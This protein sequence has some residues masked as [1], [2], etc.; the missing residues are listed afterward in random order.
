MSI[1]FE[2]LSDPGGAAG[3]YVYS[4]VAGPAV[5]GGT[6]DASTLYAAL[7]GLALEGYA[8][9]GLE[10]GGSSF[11][12]GFAI[13]ETEYEATGRQGIAIQVPGIAAAS[14]VYESEALTGGYYRV[15][16]GQDSPDVGYSYE[17]E[18]WSFSAGGIARAATLSVVLTPRP[19]RLPDSAFFSINMLAYGVGGISKE[20]L[21]DRMVASA[22]IAALY[23]VVL[24]ERF[25]LSAPA[26]TA[27]E[28][29]R[30]IVE[31]VR[32]GERLGAVLLVLIAEG[33][34]I[35]DDPVATY[36]AIA[37][38]REAMLVAGVVDTMAEAESIIASAIVLGA[39]T[40]AVF[41]ETIAELVGVGDDLGAQ[42]R[43][44]QSLI[45]GL[46]LTASAAN[47]AVGVVAVRDG[48]AITE[49]AT[50][51]AEAVNVIAE[52]LRVG[53]RIT[54][55]TGEYVAWTINTES[56]A[57]ARYENFPF[58]SF[59]IHG[60]RVLGATPAGIFAL[61]G[62]D[63]DGEDIAA[64]VRFA[65]TQMGSG[66]LKRMEAAYLGYTATGGLILKLVTTTDKRAREARL[67]RLTPRQA[68][69]DH[70][71]RVKFG[72]GTKS[73]YYG[74]EIENIDGADFGLDV[75]KVL[76]LILE[77]RITGSGRGR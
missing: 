52:A 37:T 68:G 76:P 31:D 2:S 22:D 1:V 40:D 36:T 4:A 45:D 38:V 17:A 59:A 3:A 73:V 9:S 64:R 28:S 33:L 69:I 16:V 63:D 44:V 72:R 34:R 47:T 74:F 61:E 48:V 71:A 32:I 14:H 6:A 70:E 18:A 11:V 7:A 49:G 26:T 10:Y 51:T 13:A 66:Q 25:T 54:L 19:Q 39:S 65:L 29:E 62:Q 67:F 77:R 46:R 21:L 41:R 5:V 24:D 27:A 35:G 60:G 50:S 75:V 53:L 20:T 55:D 23:R 12:N 43:A 15:N 8:F 42:V 58:N 57:V 30:L 56:R